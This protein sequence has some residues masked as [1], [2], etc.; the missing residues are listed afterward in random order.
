METSLCITTAKLCALRADMKYFRNYSKS[1]KIVPLALAI[2]AELS[3][4]A[5][6]CSASHPYTTTAPAE[7]SEFVYEGHFHVYSSITEATVWN[8]HRRMRMLCHELLAEHLRQLI[9]HRVEYSEFELSTAEMKCQL[10]DSKEMIERLA[11]EI[12]ASVPF[13]FGLHLGN[14]DRRTGT[15]APKAVCGNLL[16]RPLY[17]AGAPRFVSNRL[18]K[19]VIGRFEKI[20]EM[21]GIK[22]ATSLGH[23][24]RIGVD[25]DEWENTLQGSK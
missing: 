12:C 2:D 6:N 11:K 13:H 5:E 10:Y 3:A 21:M 20:S 18:R 25:P 7:T 23:L 1:A 4:W 22:L 14:A 16:L 19:W 15:L 17:M 8:E 24:V 9:E